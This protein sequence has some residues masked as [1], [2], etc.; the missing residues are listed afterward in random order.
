MKKD[1][2]QLMRDISERQYDIYQDIC[3]LDSQLRDNENSS[4]SFLLNPP[5][6]TRYCSRIPVRKA[7]IAEEFD[8][9]VNNFF[10]NLETK[11][12]EHDSQFAPIVKNPPQLQEQEM[13]DILN[14]GSDK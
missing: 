5:R 11:I 7:R 13:Y 4:F 6:Y 9:D 8:S 10:P 14:I 1:K 3:L 2:E 12:K